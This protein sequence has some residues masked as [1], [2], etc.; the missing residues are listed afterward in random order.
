MEIDFSGFGDM[1]DAV[2]GV[3]VEFLAPARDTHSGLDIPKFGRHRLGGT[4]AV[5]YVRSRYYEQF[6]GGG[7]TTDGTADI[8]RTERQ[9]GF[10]TTLFHSVIGSRSPVA[11]VRVA[12]AAVDGLV[13][14]A[15]LGLFD[16]FD[17]A[18]SLDAGAMATDV[19]PVTPRLTSGG[20]DVL[21]LQPSAKTVL[22]RLSS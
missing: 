13:I 20:A 9:R 3:S 17:L 4:E 11:L 8:G 7:W 5:A 21:E 19:L 1:V 12:R 16:L 6:I 15:S 18:R 14:D 2:G 10:L 22:Q